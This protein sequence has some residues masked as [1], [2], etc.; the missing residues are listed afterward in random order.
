MARPTTVPSAPTLPLDHSGPWT[1]A[2]FDALP[3]G[4]RVELLDGTLIVSPRGRVKH[5]LLGGRLF[6]VLD[7]STVPGWQAVPELEIR[8]GRDRIFIPDISVV[9]SS[10]GPDDVVV[11]AEHVGLVVEIASPSTVMLDRHVKTR[12]YA[13]ARI[14]R[15]LRVEF[16]SDGPVGEL[17]A[18]DEDGG[19]RTAQRAEVGETLRIDH[20]FPVDVDL[21]A[22][23]SDR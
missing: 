17:L 11:D 12:A 15:L 7:S 1:E 13:E 18:L 23:L 8:L 2:D 19:Y 10:V 4:S 5:Q 20:P 16:P 14:P 22:L 21:A 3:E 6:A 9:D